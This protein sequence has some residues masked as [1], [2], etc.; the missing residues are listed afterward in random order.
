MVN[1]VVISDPATVFEGESALLSCVGFGPSDVSIRWIRNGQTVIN[2]SLIN[3]YEE[4]FFQA[5]RLFTHSFLLI[6]SD[7][8]A[9]AGNYTCSVSNG[10]VSVNATTQLIFAGMWS[11]GFSI[12]MIF[13][14][15]VLKM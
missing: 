12:G 1:L 2:S 4:T 8:L 5:G 3:V 15:Q 9:D 6:C 10:L 7:N 13:S 14:S 11:K